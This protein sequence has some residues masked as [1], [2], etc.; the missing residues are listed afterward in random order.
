VAPQL[1][2]ALQLYGETL[3]TL[4]REQE[5]LDPLDEATRVYVNLADLTAA[6]LTWSHLA[7]AHERLGNFA[8]A[9]SA[10]EEHLALSKVLGNQQAE[11]EALEGLGRVAR[12]HL[13][14]SVA[15]RFYQEAI[16]RSD[17]SGDSG[18]AAAQLRWHH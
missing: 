16:A 1:G 13:P 4:D 6:A 7:R 17:A 12:R 10:W 3:I 2:Q 11:V 5:A 18:R 9:Q 14:S 8:D 15:L